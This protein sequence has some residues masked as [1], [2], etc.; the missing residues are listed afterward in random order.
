M[1]VSY[2]KNQLSAAMWG[3]VQLLWLA[4]T[5]VAL[6]MGIFLIWMGGFVHSNVSDELSAQQITFSAADSLTDEEK[7]IDGLVANA[8][9][10]LETGDQAK[11]YS[12]LILLHMSEAADGAGFPG[13]TYS[14]LG[15]EQRTLR[16]ALATAKEGTDQ[17]AIDAAQAQLDSVTALRNT[18]LTGSNLRASLLSAYGWDNVGFGV[19]I[20]GWVVV[21]MSVVFFLLF[22][23]ERR[24][25]HLA[26]VAA[27]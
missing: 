3:R 8:G 21:A 19:T 11:V 12:E 6:G 22:I 9:K 16:A 17:A 26:P 7:A 20:A 5:A 15:G 2:L 23:F 14:T 4:L 18:M 13:A 10:A 25:G 24:R 27:S 1:N